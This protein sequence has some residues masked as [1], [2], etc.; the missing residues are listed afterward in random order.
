MR[1]DPDWAEAFPVVEGPEA[2]VLILGSM[3][4]VASLRAG[5]YYNHPRNQFWRLLGDLLG[6]DLVTLDYPQRLERLSAAGIALWDV[7][8]AC[9]RRGS[10]DADIAADSMIVN[11]FAP[12]FARHPE[13]ATVCCNGGAALR[14]FRQ[15]VLPGLTRELTVIRLPS[16]SPA[17]AAMDYPSKLVLWRAAMAAIRQSWISPG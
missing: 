14:L 1:L 13:L 8:Y 3:P 16:S 6:C 15:R 4:G 2:R 12:L 7:L 5:R 17:H 10:L 9:R 11:D